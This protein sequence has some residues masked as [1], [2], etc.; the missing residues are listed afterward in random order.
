[1]AK[2][3]RGLEE[4]PKKP[5]RPRKGSLYE[6]KS[7]WRARLTIEVDG[8]AVQRSFDLQTTDKPVAKIKLRRLLKE[9]APQ[10]LAVE[11]ARPDTFEEVARRVVDEQRAAG[12][13]TWKN[14]LARLEDYVFPTLGR[15]VPGDVRA[16][17]VRAVLDGVRDAG[18]SRQTMTHVKNDISAVLGSLWRA[19]QLTENVCGRVIVPEALP[20]ASERSKLERAVLTDEEL[21]VYLGWQHPDEHHAMS[22][23]ERQVMACMARMFGGL[24]TSDLHAVKWEG[25]DVA[26][27]AFEWGTAPRR[28]GRRLAK[29]GKPQRL[30]VPDPLRPILRDWWERAGRPTAGLV[31]PKRRG[32]DAGTGARKRSGHAE[33]FRQDL[34]RAF[35][36]EALCER[37]SKRS[38]GRKL[39]TQ[40]WRDVREMTDRE[41]VL[42]TETESTLPVD[43]HSWRRA[44]NQALADAGV[45]AQQAQALAGHSTMAA[46]E[47]YLRNTQHARSIPVEALPRVLVG[48]TVSAS[49]MLK[50]SEEDPVSQ[51]ARKDSNL[52]P[53]APEAVALSS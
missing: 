42:F 6:T 44:F 52:R 22:V 19:E 36:I 1:M 27:G 47:R 12:M 46:H 48:P 10:V 3:Q 7:G 26:G 9:T 29:G 20:E 40:V 11:A 2:L 17:D 32:D 14:R 30:I 51:R 13:G 50:P 15:M 37:E 8:E 35:R 4:Q 33:A 28:K 53:T 49:P 21:V 31:F 5:G 41:R 24:R 25:F 34:R 43:F 45:N 23:L 38:N 39:T 16:A 18:R